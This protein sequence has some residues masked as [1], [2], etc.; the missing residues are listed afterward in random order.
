M[1]RARLCR[2]AGGGINVPEVTFSLEETTPEVARIT[3]TTPIIEGEQFPAGWQMRTV[4][5]ETPMQDKGLE[6]WLKS[7]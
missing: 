7:C 6:S 3:V 4:P 2:P 5:A 1:G